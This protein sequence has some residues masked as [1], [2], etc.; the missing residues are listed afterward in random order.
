[1]GRPARAHRVG[2]VEVLPGR[3]ARVAIGAD[4]LGEAR[5][6]AITACVAVG[7]TPGPRVSVVAAVHGYEAAASMAARALASEVT[8]ASLHGT[9]V[10]VPLCRPGDRFSR[11][12]KVAASLRLPGDAGG[13][14]AARLAFALHAEVI[15]GADVVITLGSPRPGRRSALLALVAPEDARARRLAESIGAAAVLP[16]RL[17]EGSVLAAAASLGRP[18]VGLLVGGAEAEQDADQLAA[19]LRRLLGAIGLLASGAPA[20]IL[21]R[22]PVI[23]AP[24]RV[25]APAHGLVEA[26]MVPGCYVRKGTPL[27]ALVPN[28]FADQKVRLLAPSAGLVLEAP[29]TPAARRGAVLFVVGP[30]RDR[31]AGA[32]RWS[33]GASVASSH[34]PGRLRTGWL[35]SVSLPDLGIARLPAKIDT[36]ARTSALHVSSS[37]V[38]GRVAG[39]SRRPILEVSVS[40]KIGQRTRQLVVRVPVKDYAAVRDTSGRLER[41][42]VIDTTLVLGTLRRRIRLT[43][44]DRG[45][46]SCPILVGRSALGSTVLVDPGARF[47]LGLPKS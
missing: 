32:G 22:P 34:A 31:G 10:V 13:S 41:R 37:R 18:A 19:A 27:G 11:A 23:S 4:A 39:P 6:S 15:V 24:D 3:A 26:A 25:R 7:S 36:G 44:T 5:S 46:M 1:M 12:G 20:A 14:R 8:P 38:V 17:A 28:D 42:P 47:L 40:T 2:G 9:L 16:A 45:D 35:E 33:A 29:A 30:T 21:A 43:L